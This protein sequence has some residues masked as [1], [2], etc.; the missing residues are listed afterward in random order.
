MLQML[1]FIVFFFEDVHTWVSEEP[2]MLGSNYG[3]G[4]EK[5]AL[6]II[7]IGHNIVKRW[8]ES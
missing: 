2:Q 1:P 4:M 8:K 3:T 6:Q 7:E 5:R